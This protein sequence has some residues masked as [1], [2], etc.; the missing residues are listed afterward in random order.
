MSLQPQQIL[1]YAAT[2][3]DFQIA[4]GAA[5]ANEIPISQVT[6]NYN[7]AWV[8]LT[9]GQ[10]LVIAVGGAALYALASNPCGWSNPAGTG[11]GETPFTTIAAPT[12]TLPGPNHFVNAAGYLAQD[13]YLAAAVLSYYALHGTYPY[14]MQPLPKLLTPIHECAP[15]AESNVVISVG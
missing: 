12:D 2:A 15:G 14:D 11:A 4:L 1:L 13:T 9:A 7:A 10:H 3:H 8:T 6:G 5:A